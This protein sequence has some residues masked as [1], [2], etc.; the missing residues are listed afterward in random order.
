VG[1]VTLPVDI[2]PMPDRVVWLPTNSAG[3]D[4]RVIGAAPGAVVTLAP[5]QLPGSPS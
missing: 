2:T 1:E 3:C 5:A 4:V